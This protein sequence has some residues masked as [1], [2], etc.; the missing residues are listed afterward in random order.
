MVPQSEGDSYFVFLPFVNNRTN[1][2]QLH[3]KLLGRLVAHS[4]LVSVYNLVPDILGQLFG[5]GHGGEFGI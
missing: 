1:C 2:C 4:S 5:L 3:T